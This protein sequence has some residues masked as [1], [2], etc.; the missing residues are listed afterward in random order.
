MG[1]EVGVESSPGSGSTFWFTLP[2]REAATV[3]AVPGA[4]SPRSET[5]SALLPERFDDRRILVAEDHPVNQQLILR[6]LQRLGCT[7]ILARDGSQAVDLAVREPFD[8]ILMECQMPEMD[9]LEATRR[10]RAHPGSSTTRV[11][12]VALTANAMDR[13]REECLAA[14]M[15]DFVTKPIAFEDLHRALARWL[16]PVA[17][18][19]SA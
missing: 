18:R 12:I 16:A 13:D 1:G 10:I 11:P 6:I 5:T 4:N 9:G 19:R 2:L 15:D 8:L 14:G 7:V 17:R 3:A